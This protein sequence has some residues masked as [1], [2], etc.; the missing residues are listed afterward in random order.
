MSTASDP[1]LSSVA[2]SW[3]ALL[4]GLLA[5]LRALGA[6]LFALARVPFGCLRRPH[7]GR[8]T[9]AS[10][11]P[12]EVHLTDLDQAAEIEQA[13]RATLIRCA[14]T[15][16]PRPLPFDR[17]EVLYGAPPRGQA[18]TFTRWAELPP[19]EGTPRHRSLTVLSLGLTDDEGRALEAAEI[20]GA[21]AV[22]VRSVLT[23]RYMN[24]HPEPVPEAKHD[25]TAVDPTGAAPLPAEPTM[26]TIRGRATRVAAPAP[27]ATDPAVS[28]PDAPTHSGRV[29]A[30]SPDP[31][32]VESSAG[33]VVGEPSEGS[34][35]K[36]LLRLVQNAENADP[37]RRTRSRNPGEGD[38][39]R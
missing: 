32:L 31:P 21:I 24:E 33:A 10:R 11:I 13:V 7:A 39:T 14:R 29:G 15:W 28:R 20:A 9:P 18:S 6:L 2:G 27:T 1:A 22:Q 3:R 23:R 37:L 17:V 35:A 36:P 26:S 34:A 25:E 30:P 38:E 16:A 4:V 19:A 12:I 5:T 8:P